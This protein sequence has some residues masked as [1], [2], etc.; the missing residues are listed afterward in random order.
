MPNTLVSK[1]MV[2]FFRNKHPISL[3][4]CERISDNDIIV[5]LKIMQFVWAAP[6]PIIA[7]CL[8]IIME[9]LNLWLLTDTGRADN[10][11]GHLDWTM[12][13]M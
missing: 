11:I 3:L 4:V 13:P 9:D 6:L 2:V 10:Q 12:D 1:N 5:R 8:G 7:V